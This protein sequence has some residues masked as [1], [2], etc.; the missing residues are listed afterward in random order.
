[1]LTGLG[2]AGTTPGP[3]IMVVQFRKFLSAYRS[4]TGH[5]PLLAAGTLRGL[6]ARLG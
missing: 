2:M 1:M 4:P 6:L 3:L 5:F